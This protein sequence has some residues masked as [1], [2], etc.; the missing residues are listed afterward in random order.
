MQEAVRGLQQELQERDAQ[1]AAAE[2][3]LKRDE[4]IFAGERLAAHGTML[5]GQEARLQGRAGGQAE[6]ARRSNI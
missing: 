2:L 6:D 1:L 4:D 3:D 5:S